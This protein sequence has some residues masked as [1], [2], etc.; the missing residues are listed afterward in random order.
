M[1]EQRG[2]VRA[3]TVELTTE[4]TE[5]EL[6]RE[7]VRSAVR[8]KQ[9]KRQALK[10]AGADVADGS[11]TNLGTVEQRLAKRSTDLMA[12]HRARLAV[13]KRGVGR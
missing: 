9:A 7:K 2:P 1:T 12:K 8:A 4:K 13:L 10:R 11:E 5:D 6:E 3:S